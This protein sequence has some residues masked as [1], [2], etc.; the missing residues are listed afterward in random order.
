MNYHP[1]WRQISGQWVNDNGNPHTMAACLE[2]SWNTRHSSTAGYREV[3]RQ[4]GEAIAAYLV[5]EKDE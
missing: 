5:L 4:L 2:T 3:G 1:L